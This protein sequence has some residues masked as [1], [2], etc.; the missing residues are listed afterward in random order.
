[1]TSSWFF[2]SSTVT[3]MQVQKTSSFRFL[4]LE[5]ETR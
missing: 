4:T 5:D 3:M 1:V 2:Y